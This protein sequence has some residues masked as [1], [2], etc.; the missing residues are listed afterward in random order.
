[1][2]R[3][4]CLCF[5]NWKHEMF[6]PMRSLKIFLFCGLLSIVFSGCTAYSV[7]PAANTPQTHVIIKDGNFRYV[8]KVQGEWSS[9][10]VLG[11]GGMSN[12]SLANNSIAKMYE[13]ARL[14]DGQTIINM[15]THTSIQYLFLGIVTKETSVT[16]GYVI[17]FAD[18]YQNGKETNPKSLNSEQNNSHQKVEVDDEPKESQKLA[19]EIKAE[20]ENPEIISDAYYAFIKASIYSMKK[21]DKQ[22]TENNFINEIRSDIQKS[23]YSYEFDR[24][25]RKIKYLEQYSVT[26][27]YLKDAVNSLKEEL[28]ERKELH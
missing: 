13:N 19:E 23:K 12:Q 3:K 16:T 24:I 8:K 22:N 9:T 18:N 28:K 2:A 14:K 21:L 1:M 10:Y 27:S 11:I 7:I 6:L 20:T 25:E 17:E 5:G 15:A 26:R 4:D